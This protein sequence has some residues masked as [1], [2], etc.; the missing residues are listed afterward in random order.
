VGV[1]PA[2]ITKAELAAA[3]TIPEQW[4][5]HAKKVAA[6]RVGQIID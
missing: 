3:R 6:N 4:L 1:P 5:H 2:T